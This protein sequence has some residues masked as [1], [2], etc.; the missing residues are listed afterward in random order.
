MKA[1]GIIILALVLFA[2]AEGCKRRSKST[3]SGD[4]VKGGAVSPTAKNGRGHFTIGKAT[5]YVTGPVDADGRI[6]YVL[7]S[8]TD[9][10]EA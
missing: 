10:V 9:S 8:M 7:R 1:L 2:T 5:T 3:G 6:D 4:D